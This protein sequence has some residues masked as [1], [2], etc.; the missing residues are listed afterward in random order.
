[1][2][3]RKELICSGVK[4]FSIHPTILNLTLVTPPSITNIA[5]GAVDIIV[6]SSQPMTLQ[7]WDLLEEA[8]NALDGSWGAPENLSGGGKIV[9]CTSSH[10]DKD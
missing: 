3:P 5:K 8:V 6:P 4:P 7:E 9:I 2:R 10:D 1:M